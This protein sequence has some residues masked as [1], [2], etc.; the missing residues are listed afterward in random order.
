[1]ARPPGLYAEALANID[2]SLAC[3]AA[4]RPEPTG[5]ADAFT[6][7]DSMRGFLRIARGE[8]TD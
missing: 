6:V 4:Q 7:A 1:M 3:I 8:T 2:R 5:G